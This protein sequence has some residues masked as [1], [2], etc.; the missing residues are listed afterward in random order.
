MSSTVYLHELDDFSD[1]IS[2]VSYEKKIHPQLV[3]T[4]FRY[5]KRDQKGYYIA[6]LGGTI[7]L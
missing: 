7:S 4:I 6:T 5:N 1:L 3:N 2:A